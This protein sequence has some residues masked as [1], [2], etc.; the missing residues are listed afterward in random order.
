MPPACSLSMILSSQA[1]SYL[2]SDGSSR[3]HEKIASDTRL[4]PA[5]CM[6]WTSSS[7]TRSGHWSGL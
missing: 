7:H 4:T 2:P 5:S 6:R 1:K 3:D